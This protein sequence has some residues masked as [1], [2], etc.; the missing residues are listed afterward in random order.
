MKR[1]GLLLLAC[2]LLTGCA[3]GERGR[4]EPEASP[5]YQQ[6]DQETAMQMMEQDDGHVIVDVRQPDEYESGHIP[7]AICIPNESID[8]QRPEELP[9]PGQILLL[10]CRSGN[11][12]KQAAEKLAGLGCTQVYEFGGISDWTGEIVT[13]Q[14]LVL[15]VEANPTTGFSWQAAQDPERFEI[16]SSYI[17]EPRAGAVSGA[18]GWQ[19][20][21]LTPKQAGTAQLSFTY[22]RPWEP[23][24]QDPQFRC[25]LEISEELGI[26]V[27]EDGTAQAAERGYT[28]TW[29]IY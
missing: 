8:G 7:G 22:T 13:G 20:F 28:A 19:R 5:G 3:A 27:T 10:Y 26:T 4:E 15:T 14:T 29:K 18:G 25:S 16:R 2:L 21:I 24:D 23:S 9:N 17:A 12:S 6:I 11:C 1:M